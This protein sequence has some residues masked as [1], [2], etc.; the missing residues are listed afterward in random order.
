MNNIFN[1]DSDLDEVS[2]ISTS[3]KSVKSDISWIDKDQPNSFKDFGSP[4]NNNFENFNFPFEEKKIDDHI[5]KKS[6]KN[7]FKIKDNLSEF[8]MD[9]DFG[10]FSDKEKGNNDSESSLSILQ[11]KTKRREINCNEDDDGKD[12]KQKIFN[13]EKVENDKKFLYRK[14]YFIM[15]F[16]GNFLNWLLEELQSLIDNCKFCKKFGKTNFH[17]AN[18]ELYGGNPKEEDNREFILKTIEEVFTLTEEQ[19]KRLN[20]I[21]R[22]ISNEEIIKKI[23]E[24]SEKLRVKIE[25]DEKYIIQLNAIE[26]F[27]KFIRMPIKDALDIYYDS[28]E[29]IRFKSTRK[30]QYYD[31]M[32]Y[33]ERNRNF[34]LLE[35]NNFVRFVNLP[36]YSK[37][38]KE[39]K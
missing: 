16:K 4:I 7:N 12:K 36:F 8:P 33:S 15:D 24:Y 11:K 6:F 21:S 3:S 20:K 34:S 35:K 32:F 14:D 5:F 2:M 29:F 10:A 39:K 26:E 37:K 17:I 25:K 30:I 28:V 1:L 9:E 22:Q 31:K 19:K 18:R 23:K 38:N 27:L 13:I